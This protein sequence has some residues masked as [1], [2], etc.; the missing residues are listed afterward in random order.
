MTTAVE[1]TDYLA[2]CEK[3][4]YEFVLLLGR[5]EITDALEDA[6]LAAGCDDATL[7]CIDGN[8]YLQFD[9]EAESLRVA[10]TSAIRA[11]ENCGQP[12]RVLAVYPPNAKEIESINAAL[13]TRNDGRSLLHDLE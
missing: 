6:L 12:I 10:V 8:L 4:L 5:G 13:K 2:D 7:S 1:N 3:D 9:R 11:V